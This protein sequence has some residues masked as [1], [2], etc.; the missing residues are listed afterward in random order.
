V[1]DADAPELFD[2]L[3]SGLGLAMVIAS[4]VVGVLTIG[5]IWRSRF[6]VAR[7]TSGMAVGTMLVGWALAQRPDILPGELTFQDAAAG[8]STLLAT[9]IALALA[10]AVIIPS[11]T[12]LFKLT[13][14][15]RL[16]EPPHPIAP[17]D[18]REREGE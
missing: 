8:D 1:L 10:L 12:W 18:H 17:L 7:Y 6:E 13:L 16:Y 2:G 15:G 11:L 14:E 9:L 5:L 4:A 3:T